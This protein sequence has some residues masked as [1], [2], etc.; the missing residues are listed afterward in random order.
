MW[1][2]D[3]GKLKDEIYWWLVRDF[4]LLPVI[5]WQMRMAWHSEMTWL[6]FLRS[7]KSGTVRSQSSEISRFSSWTSISRLEILLFVFNL[8]IKENAAWRWLLSR[9][10]SM[11]AS[12]S[13]KHSNSFPCF[14][15]NLRRVKI[16]FIKSCKF[17][18]I[19]LWNSTQSRDLLFTTNL[20]II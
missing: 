4:L 5:C 16:S 8:L 1:D 20:E 18:M 10:S 2:L 7:L 13:Y 19:C 17:S 3:L 9:R 14:I 12:L 15:I 6:T 11:S